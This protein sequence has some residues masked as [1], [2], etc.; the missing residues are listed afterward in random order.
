MHLDVVAAAV[1]FINIPFGYWRANVPRRSTC[2]FLAIHLPIPA[3]VM[4]RVHSGIGFVWFSYPILLG[5]YFFGQLF[6]GRLKLWLA[7]CGPARGSSCIA[8]ALLPSVTQAGDE[9]QEEPGCAC[10]ARNTESVN[11]AVCKEE[12]LNSGT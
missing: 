2:W 11:K 4:L 7:G 3:I 9:S 6:G 8:G 12:A 10:R 5:T 1:F